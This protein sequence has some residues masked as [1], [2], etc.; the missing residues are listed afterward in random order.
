M[1]SLTSP[2]R[3]AR[4]TGRR[5][6]RPGGP[7]RMPGTRH[8][9]NGVVRGAPTYS[10]AHRTRSNSTLSQ[11]GPAPAAS[12]S[13]HMPAPRTRRGVPHIG[14]AGAQTVGLIGSGAGHQP[15]DSSGDHLRSRTSVAVVELAARAL[16]SQPARLGDSDQRTMLRQPPPSQH[17][18]IFCRQSSAPP[19]RAHPEE[20]V[21][22]SGELTE[23][24]LSVPGAPDGR[25]GRGPS[26]GWPRPTSS[27]RD[28]PD[29]VQASGRSSPRAQLPRLQLD[30]PPGRRPL[31]A[32]PREEVGAGPRVPPSC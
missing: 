1:S 12:K 8:D 31:L 27:V 16:S 3:R 18:S 32:S 5:T 10:R 11:P 4:S 15:G 2:R 19:R 24:V 7:S 9:Y 22:A 29:A 21:R 26:A 30:G 28:R 25:P 6:A 14:R 20:T 13:D 23:H 17:H